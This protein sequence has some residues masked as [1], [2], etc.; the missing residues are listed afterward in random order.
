MKLGIK[1]EEKSLVAGGKMANSF[2][3]N[4]QIIKQKSKQ[5]SLKQN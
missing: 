4:E 5:R 2:L 1:R 3:P